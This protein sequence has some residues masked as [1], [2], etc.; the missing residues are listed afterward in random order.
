[1]GGNQNYC[2]WPFIPL[3]AFQRSVITGVLHS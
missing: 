1:L 3:K 2:A